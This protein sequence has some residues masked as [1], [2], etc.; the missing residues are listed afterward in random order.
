MK[1]K[2]ANPEEKSR[3]IPKKKRE[4]PRWD[5]PEWVEENERMEREYKQLMR[6][7]ERREIKEEIRRN[8]EKK[9]PKKIRKRPNNPETW[10]IKDF[11]SWNIR[12]NG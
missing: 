3:R 5:D 1:S 9:K 4:K 12:R 2:R 11:E 10:P 6:E 7:R 8:R